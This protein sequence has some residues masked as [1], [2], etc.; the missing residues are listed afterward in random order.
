MMKAYQAP[1]FEFAELN[2]IDVVTASGDNWNGPDFP[3][4]GSGNDDTTPGDGWTDDDFW[5]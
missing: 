4:S 5:N 3:G 2:P 1:N